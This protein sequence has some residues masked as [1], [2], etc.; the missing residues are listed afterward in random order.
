MG[1]S[2][3][4]FSE[5]LGIYAINGVDGIVGR[6]PKMLKLYRH[7]NLLADVPVNVL[8]TGEMALVKP[9]WRKAFIT[10]GGGKR[11]VSLLR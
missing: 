2:I 8:I 1:A 11:V 7:I 10:M 4:H 9:W 5:E 3:P 6:D